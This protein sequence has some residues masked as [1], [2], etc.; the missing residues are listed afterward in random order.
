M[1]SPELIKKTG[2]V[3][4]D[5]EIAE[6]EE[7]FTS[8]YILKRSDIERCGELL[9]ELE[10][11]SYFGRNNCPETASRTY[12]IMTHRSGNFPQCC[13]H[14]WWKRSLCWKVRGS[15][16]LGGQGIQFGQA[17]TR[18][19]GGDNLTLGRDGT[20]IQAQCYNW[21]IWSH[22]RLNYLQERRTTCGGCGG[23][24]R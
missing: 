12:E 15:G 18:T 2:A 7:K 21:Q 13:K 20:N 6:E 9:E 1:P 22:L 24:G 14:S 16:H 3:A 4:I 23:G 8:M 10:N 11:S 5:E 19:K 17:S